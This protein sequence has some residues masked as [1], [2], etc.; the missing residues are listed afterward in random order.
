MDETELSPTRPWYAAPWL[1][2]GAIGLFLLWMTFALAAYYV[3]QKPFDADIVAAMRETTTVWWR[4]PFS[5]AAMGRSLL[6]G[7]TAVWLAFVALGV[8]LWL[9]RGLRLQPEADLATFLYAVGLGFGALAIG[10][11]LLGIAGGLETAVLFGL[12][13]VLTLLTGKQALAFL[14]LAR[15][16]R[17]PA[18]LLSYLALVLG[19]ALFVA[20]LPPHSWDGISYHLKGPQLYLAAGRIGPTPD[21]PHI[22]PIYFPNLLEMLFM[23]AM[24]LRGDVAAQMVHFLFVF[25][26]MGMVY[27]AARD[28]VKANNPWLA[29]VFFAAMPM[30]WQLATQAYNDLALAFFQLGALVALG[31]WQ[32]ARRANWLALAGIFC[33]LAMGH[34][35]TSFVT[36][37]VLALLL[38]W[39]FRRRWPQAIRPFLLLALVTTL[40]ASPWYVKNWWLTGNPVYPFLFNGAGWDDYLSQAYADA[41]SGIGW[42]ALALLRL[43]L[44]VTTGVNDVSGDGQAGPFFLIFLPL[45]LLYAFSPMGRRASRPFR[46]LLFFALMQYLFW[47]V[48]VIYSAGLNQTRQ[49]FPAFVAL[50]PALAWIWEE[51]TRYDH[52]QFSLRRFVGLVLAFAFMLN[53]LGIVLNWL[54]KAPHTYVLGSDTRAATLARP[55]LLGVHYLAMAGINEVVPAEGVVTFLWEPRS[56]YCVRDCRPDVLLYRF[57]HLDHLYGDAAGIARSWQEAGVT[58]V[59]LFEAGY[60]FA[61]ANEMRWIAPRDTAVMDTLRA[62]WLE[63]VRVWE[64]SYTLYALK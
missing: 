47:T 28:Q 15:P 39:D 45:L 57:S 27:L 48:G 14:R 54:P 22:A 40:V 25:F 64:G 2:W 37:L 20:L 1:K 30:V 5:A 3:S 12:M 55:S 11:L 7:L 29:V 26:L 9:L 41:G 8:G 61:V 16:G 31:Q 44:D 50:C 10:M 53:L 23:L 63:P 58:H 49:L 21:A 52:P 32:K 33:G 38:L 51:L 43:P 60:D 24:G 18:L 59:L 62:H 56:Y 35:Y 17:P 19:L 6:D 13:L 46:Q 34:K 36:P 42:D 4:F